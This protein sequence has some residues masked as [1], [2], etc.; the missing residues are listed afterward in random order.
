MDRIIAGFKFVLR[1]VAAARL[2]ALMGLTFVDV[3]ARYVLA[4]PIQ[5]AFE[6]GEF[7]LALTVF[8]ALP[9]VTYEE[10]HVTIEFF[11]ARS[12]SLH[13]LA[14]QIVSAAVFGLIAVLAWRQGDHYAEYGRA[15]G[16]LEIPLA[17][18]CYGLSVL[19]GISTALLVL[20]I[21]EDRRSVLTGRRI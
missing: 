11:K 18:L 19:G 2:F 20:R 4:A 6:I 9:L 17:P 7:I 8:A 13:R 14:V 12:G 1:L 21:V 10:G 3:I 5:G 16:L 15:T